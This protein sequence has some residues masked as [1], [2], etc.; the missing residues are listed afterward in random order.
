MISL[1]KLKDRYENIYEDLYK[2]GKIT[3][4]MQEE[5]M[6]ISLNEVKRKLISNNYDK[7]FEAYLI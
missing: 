5:T 4:R 1:P 3:D 2:E 7:S 6:K